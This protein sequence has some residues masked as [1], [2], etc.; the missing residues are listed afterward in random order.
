M[1]RHSV[2]A[3][4]AGV[5]RFRRAGGGRRIRAA[6]VAMALAAAQPTAQAAGPAGFSADHAAAWSWSDVASGALQWAQST[7]IAVYGAASELARSAINGV[8]AISSTTG[9]V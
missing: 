2:I 5:A 6:V 4:R 8:E 1:A 9:E 3:S 7:V